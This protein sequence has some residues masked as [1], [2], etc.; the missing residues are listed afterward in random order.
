M[1]APPAPS[2]AA[3]RLS[4]LC[5]GAIAAT[6][7]ATVVLAAPALDHSSTSA[8]HQAGADFG[9]PGNAAAVDR[10]IPIKV[11]DLSFDVL[12]LTVNA[13]ETV[14]FVVTNDGAADHEFTLGDAATQKA[15]RQAI[16]EMTSMGGGHAQHG[17][18]NALFLK[19]GETKELVWRFGQVGRI[20]F[21]CDVPGHFEAGMRGIVIIL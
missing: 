11:G 5:I 9:A 19:R 18:A 17:E 1:S 8:R 2:R 4:P 10:I 12:V 14:R 15:H 13:G 20:E 21:A 7:S 3:R 16:A 6:L